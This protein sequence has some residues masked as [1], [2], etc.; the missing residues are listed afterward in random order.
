[1]IVVEVI[2]MGQEESAGMGC[3]AGAALELLPCI[4]DD[5]NRGVVGKEDFSG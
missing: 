4:L 3:G 2:A 5:F 1:V